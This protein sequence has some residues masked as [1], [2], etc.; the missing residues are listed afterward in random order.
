MQRIDR[1]VF[2]E[3]GIRRGGAVKGGVGHG[4]SRCKIYVVCAAL[5]VRAQDCN[6]DG[7]F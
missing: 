5:K 4:N 3:R 7:R 1:N 6:S 2:S